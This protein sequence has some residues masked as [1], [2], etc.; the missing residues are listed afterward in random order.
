VGESPPTKE[1]AFIGRR[2]VALWLLALSVV[3]L[4]AW[5]D[6]RSRRILNRLTVPAVI[7]GVAANSLLNGWTGTKAALA[8]AGLML[9][10]FLPM[11]WLRALG[12]G[13]GKL[14]VALGA[15]LG[16]SQ[17]VA[18]LFGAVLIS[19]LMAVVMIVRREKVKETLRNMGELVKGFAVFGFRP[20]PVLRL[21]NQQLSSVPF[22]VAAAMAT[23][24]CFG[25]IAFVGKF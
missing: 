7:L 9:L 10:L 19:G 20:H 2:R 1:V 22:G 24:I 23:L 12:A 17:V 6:W 15:F 13:D 14:M 5:T 8:G 11:V 3:G 4:A 21:E 25:G 16:P 18:V